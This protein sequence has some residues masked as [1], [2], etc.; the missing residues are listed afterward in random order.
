L[1]SSHLAEKH[2]SVHASG[3]DLELR[4]LSGVGH[5][6]YDHIVFEMRQVV[7]MNRLSQSSAR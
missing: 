2:L 3:I 7:P 6:L 4:Y 5:D 1:D